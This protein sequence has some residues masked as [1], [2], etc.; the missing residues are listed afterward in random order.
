[1]ISRNQDAVQALV[2][3]DVQ[4]RDRHLLLMSREQG[5]KHRFLLGHDERH[6]LVAGILEASP[7][8]RVADAKRALKP[9]KPWS[10]KHKVRGTN[11][12][13]SRLFMVPRRVL[14][15]WVLTVAKDY[16]YLA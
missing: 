16:G 11:R 4:P 14:E 12:A 8:S 2:V 1:M 3:L 6:W 9:R 7:V 15:L 10:P 5:Q 13:P